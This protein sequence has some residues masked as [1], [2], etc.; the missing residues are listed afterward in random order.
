MLLVAVYEQRRVEATAWTISILF[1]AAYYVMHAY[2]VHAVTLPSDLSS[3]GWI[4]TGGWRFVL[5][6]MQDGTL[7]SAL[8]KSVTAVSVPFALVGWCAWKNPI[9]ARVAIFLC[10]YIVLFMVI[11]RTNNNYWGM[12][13]APF[14]PI[15]LV[16]ALPSV[17]VLCRH[18]MHV[19]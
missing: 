1:G 17:K 11:G 13:L 5:L 15:G 12:L 19:N 10:T 4:A 8:P 9:G 3:E 18:A 16:F 2:A 6:C 7:F 14:V